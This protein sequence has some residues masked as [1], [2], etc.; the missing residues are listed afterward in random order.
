MCGPAPQ[1]AIL[2][3]G[4]ADLKPVMTE[5][6][7]VEFIPHMALSLTIN[8]QVIDGAPAARFMQT[9]TKILGDIELYL[10]I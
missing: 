9:L 2:G 1:V 7:D 8:H 5:D 6:G 4:K 3:V 10:A